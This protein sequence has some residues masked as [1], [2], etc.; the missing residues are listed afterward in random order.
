MEKETLLS[1]KW[2]VTRPTFNGSVIPNVSCKL[3]SLYFIITL[4]LFGPKFR[5]TLILTLFIDAIALLKKGY[6][7]RNVA[8]LT[9]RF[10]STI[11]RVKKEFC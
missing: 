6:A 8:K 2:Y 4:I 5:N 10:I 11:Q 3:K 1:P 7:I 9:G